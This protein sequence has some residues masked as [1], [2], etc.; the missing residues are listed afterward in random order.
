MCALNH[1]IVFNRFDGENMRPRHRTEIV[2]KIENKN[3]NQ[4]ESAKQMEKRIRFVCCL[5]LNG[6]ECAPHL[7][8]WDRQSECVWLWRWRLL[9]FLSIISCSYYGLSITHVSRIK[10]FTFFAFV[11]AVGRIN[12]GDHFVTFRWQF[13]TLA[14]LNWNRM[15]HS[16]ILDDELLFRI[17]FI[18]G[19]V[20]G[21]DPPPT[22]P[23]N[24]SFFF[25]SHSRNTM[26]VRRRNM[27]AALSKHKI[28]SILIRRR[29]QCVWSV[30]ACGRSPCNQW[31]VPSHSQSR[32]A[33]SPNVWVF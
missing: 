18:V 8:L 26:D 9:G 33:R 10:E 5:W 24:F 31:S 12:V 19:S 11:A 25:V 17:H 15:A 16:D 7:T 29:A 28:A 3:A 22:N 13:L 27:I 20:H 2:A 6:S 1:E 14:K 21:R 32:R 30:A 4:N 23:N